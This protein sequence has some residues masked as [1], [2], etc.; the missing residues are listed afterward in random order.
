MIA[1]KLCIGDILPGDILLWRRIDDTCRSVMNS[2]FIV[3][4]QSVTKQEDPENL[5]QGH[6]L[7]VLESRDGRN[8]VRN[9]RE[10]RWPTRFLSTTLESCEYGLIR[11]GKI[12]VHI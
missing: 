7:Y 4:V 11:D 5:F 1:K 6:K 2:S 12:L 3:S 10:Y 8:L 9:L